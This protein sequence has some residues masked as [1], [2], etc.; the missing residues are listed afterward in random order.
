VFRTAYFFGLFRRTVLGQSA[1]A[2]ARIDLKLTSLIRGMTHAKQI[3]STAV[4][5]LKTQM[6]SQ[7]K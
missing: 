5:S 1:L 4:G 6:F 7:L 2:D 3:M